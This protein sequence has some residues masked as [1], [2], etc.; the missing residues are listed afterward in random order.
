MTNFHQNNITQQ[1]EFPAK[2]KAFSS[3][4]S[5]DKLRTISELIFTAIFRKENQTLKEGA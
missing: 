5:D 3:K 1:R 4:T 2:E